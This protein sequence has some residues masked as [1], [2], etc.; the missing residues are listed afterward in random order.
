MVWRIFRSSAWAQAAPKSPVEAPM[1][2]MAEF[3]HRTYAAIPAGHEG[4][5]IDIGGELDSLLWRA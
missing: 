4:D 2:A 1:T 3:L 5:F